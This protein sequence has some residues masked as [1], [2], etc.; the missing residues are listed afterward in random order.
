MVFEDGLIKAGILVEDVAQTFSIS[1]ETDICSFPMQAYKKI[2]LAL[3]YVRDGFPTR[4]FEISHLNAFI[5][6]EFVSGQHLKTFNP[7]F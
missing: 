4:I 5:I 6:S 2:K 3:V 7:S 1:C